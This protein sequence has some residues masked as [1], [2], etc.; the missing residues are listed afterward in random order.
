M[1]RELL[2]MTQNH[3]MPP[4]AAKG[5]ESSASTKPGAPEAGPIAQTGTTTWAEMVWAFWSATTALHSEQTVQLAV[6]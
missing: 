1:V 5:L 3:R 4:T 2:V 6:S